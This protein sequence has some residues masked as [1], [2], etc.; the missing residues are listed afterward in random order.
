MLNTPKLEK[1]IQDLFANIPPTT[2]ST[3]ESPV[4][5]QKEQPALP[6]LR[7][8]KRRAHRSHTTLIELDS[9]ASSSPTTCYDDQYF[10]TTSSS[11]FE[12]G[13]S[14]CKRGRGRPA[15]PIL[16]TPPS[17]ANFSHLDEVETK[18]HILRFK[19]NEASRKS[20]RTRRNKDLSIGTQ[21]ENLEERYQRLQ[22]VENIL[23]DRLQMLQ[24]AVIRLATL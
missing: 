18:R 9:S 12:D 11:V 20:R 17:P 1:T 16:T 22:R 6:P 4:I 2:S 14:P 3:A 24:Q 21:C 23:K 19:N 5:Q 10:E 8:R 13:P 7:I 15:K